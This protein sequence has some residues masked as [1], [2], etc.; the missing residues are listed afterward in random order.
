MNLFVDQSQYL[1]LFRPLLS[2]LNLS[3][4]LWLKKE[5][6]YQ[7]CGSHIFFSFSMVYEILRFASVGVSAYSLAPARLSHIFEI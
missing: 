5:K 2:Y 3:E 4:M 7:K 6:I 1:N